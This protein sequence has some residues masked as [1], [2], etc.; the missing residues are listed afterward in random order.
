MI[1][2]TG[3]YFETKDKSFYK[4]V[5]ELLEKRWNECITLKGEYVNE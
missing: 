5:I 2:E 4:K 3:T 1:A